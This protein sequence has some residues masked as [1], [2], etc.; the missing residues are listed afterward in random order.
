MADVA[1]TSLSSHNDSQKSIRLKDDLNLIYI[2]LGI[3]LRDNRHK[4]EDHSGLNYKCSNMHR[5]E[6]LQNM[7]IVLLSIEASR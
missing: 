7:T 6:C 5:T 1:Y 3:Q 2:T 4:S